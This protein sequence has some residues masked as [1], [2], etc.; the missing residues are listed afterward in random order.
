MWS[1]YSS[2]TRLTPGENLCLHRTGIGTAFA[3]NYAGHSW[4]YVS[5]VLSRSYSCG[6]ILYGVAERDKSSIVLNSP[7]GP[8]VD[9]EEKM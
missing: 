2:R 3:N 4:D 8:Y 5:E 9:R 6:L 7:A 1:D